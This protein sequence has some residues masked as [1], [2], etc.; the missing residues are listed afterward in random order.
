MKGYQIFPEIVPI[1]KIYWSSSQFLVSSNLHR[2]HRILKLHV[3]SQ[4]LEAWE[5]KLF[6][7]WDVS[8]QTEFHPAFPY[9]KTLLKLTHG[10]IWVQWSANW[11]NFWEIFGG[12]QVNYWI[13]REK[14]LMLFFDLAN[15]RINFFT[16]TKS[17]E[18]QSSWPYSR[19]ETSSLQLFKNNQ[20]IKSN[21]FSISN[22]IFLAN[23]LRNSLTRS[24]SYI[25]YSNT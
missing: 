20:T 3:A 10:W 2:Y 14:I 8:F 25:V 4:K 16:K 6:S 24:R 12:R 19:L 15:I 11:A 17:L 9:E 13:F 22:I 5:K 7:F 1:E 18:N 21:M 23:M